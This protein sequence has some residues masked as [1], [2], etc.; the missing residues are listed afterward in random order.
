M[1][2]EEIN[3]W[4][5]AD[6]RKS[7]D[8]VAIVE[9]FAQRLIDAGVP[10]W[11]A[12]VAQRLS[13]PLLAAWGVIWTPEETVDYTVPI[14]VLQTGTWF[15]SPFEYVTRTLQ[16][17]QK[18]L[19]D[20]D[21]ERDHATYIELA[22]A[23]GTDFFA[24]VLEY[25]DGSTQG[26]SFVSNVTGGFSQSHIDLIQSCRHALAAALE[27]AAMRRSSESLLRT[28]LGAGPAKAVSEG[29]INRGELT[30]IDAVVMFTDMRDF[31]RKSR[32]WNERDLLQALDEYFEIVVDAV[33]KNGGDVLKFM[34]DG[35][36]SVFPISDSCPTEE[37]CHN[38]TIAAQQMLA[39][40]D[41]LNAER[42][43]DAKE[44]L[45][46]GTGI[47]SG[48]VTYGNIGSPD[49]LDFTVMG[50]A[51]NLASRIQDL[52]K[53]LGTPVLATHE[54]AH[55]SSDTYSSLGTHTVRGLDDPVEVFAF[56]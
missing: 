49:R 23:G 35:V 54:V 55:S 26:C 2:A 12:R 40:L 13:N 32:E 9:G 5:I 51:V 50:Q 30:R 8:S 25:G 3:S 27:A 11:R 53:I 19:V 7:G 21:P 15:G 1:T 28:Y 33:H 20:L 14:T 31:T 4:L 52:C 46:F 43:K 42:R 10:L 41:D 17:L 6:A 34:G 37:C 44:P 48:T 16:P 36:L 47:H 39:A 18:S 45:A 22:E 56:R 38:A 29:T 24:T